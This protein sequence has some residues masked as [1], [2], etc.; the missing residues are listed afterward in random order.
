[1]TEF[2]RCLT[3]KGKCTGLS[4]SEPKKGQA[5]FNQSCA[6]L[7][8]LVGDCLQL[9]QTIIFFWETQTCCEL[10]IISSSGSNGV[11]ITNHYIILT[12]ERSN[13]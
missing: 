8:D 13:T 2:P 11:G 4:S 7:Y 1:M 10:S 9:T 12:K 3:C 5:V 6:P